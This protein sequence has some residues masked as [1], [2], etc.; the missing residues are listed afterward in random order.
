MLMTSSMA[1]PDLS[2]LDVR[3]T[4]ELLAMGTAYGW[5]IRLLLGIKF[6]TAVGTT[7]LGS[8]SIAFGCGFWKAMAWPSGATILACPLLPSIAGTMMTIAL[9]VLYNFYQDGRR[10]Q[11]A[12]LAAEEKRRLLARHEYRPPTVIELNYHVPSRRRS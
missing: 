5:L 2:T 8:T 10:R 6:V 4:L 3:T 1:V 9:L 7:S 12:H 11:E